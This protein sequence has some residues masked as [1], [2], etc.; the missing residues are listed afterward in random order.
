MIRFLCTQCRKVVDQVELPPLPACPIPPDVWSSLRKIPLG[1]SPLLARPLDYDTLVSI[2]QQLIEG[3][4]PGCD[5][6]PR[7]FY[8]YAPQQLLMLLLSAINAFIEGQDPT[9]HPEE[10]LGALVTLLPK[11]LGSIRITDYRPIGKPC[12]KFVVFSK[13]VDHNFRRALEDYKIV[14][15]EQEGFRAHRSTK[16]QITKLQCL[17]RRARERNTISVRLYLDI[18]NAFN[19]VN[20]RAMLEILRACG[21]PDKDVELFRRMYGNA[22]LMVAN[23]F[24]LSA[25]CTLLRGVLQGAPTSPNVF[26]VAFNPV[27]VLIKACKRGCSP[28]DDFD[29]MGSSGFADDTTLHTDG[30]DAVPA[31]QV[32]VDAISPFC[33]WL[34]LLLNLLKSYVSAVNHATGLQVPTDSIQYHG[35]PFPALSPDS[36][37]KVLGVYMT[38]T[39]NYTQHKEYI[40]TKMRTRCQAL[41]KDDVIPRGELRELAITSGVVS[42]FR[43][44]AGVVPW[45]KTELDAIYKLWIQA[46]KQAWEYPTSLDASPIIVG[47][48]DGGRGCPSAHKVWIDDTMAVLDQ[49]LQLPG[50]ISTLVMEHIRVACSSRGCATLNQ[51][52]KVLRV[53]GTADSIIELLTLRLDE[54]G[55]DISTPWPQRSS[56]LILEALWP[57][58]WQAWQ[59]K[60]KWKGCTELSEEV[61]EQW[62]CAKLYLKICSKLGKVDMLSL[63]QLRPTTGHG[64]TWEELQRQR[65]NITRHEFSQL[66]S[67]LPPVAEEQRMLG[68]PAEAVRSRKDHR[69]LAIYSQ[70]SLGSA[71]DMFTTLPPYIVGKVLSGESSDLIELEFCPGEPIPEVTIDQLSDSMLIAHLCKNRATLNYTADGVSYVTVE[72]LT[73]LSRVWNRAGN[74]AAAVVQPLDPSTLPVSTRLGVLGV[75]LIRD[76]LKEKAAESLLE[77]CSRPTWRI[78]RT[79]L[80]K[81]FPRTCWYGAETVRQEQLKWQFL[82]SG[83]NGLQQMTGLGQGIQRKRVLAPIKQ[84]IPHYIW[85][86]D[87]PIPSNVTIDLSNHIPKRLLAPSGWEVRQ[88]NARVLITDPQ[89]QTF[90]LDAAQYGMLLGLDNMRC[91]A[92][93]TTEPATPTDQF[94]CDLRQECQSQRRC[95]ANFGVPWNRHLITCLQQITEAR[96]LVGPSA[97]TYNPHFPLLVSP[98]SRCATLGAVQEWPDVSALLLL[99]SIAPEDRQTWLQLAAQH[100]QPVWILRLHHPTRA[101]LEDLRALANLQARCV[102]IIPAKSNILHKSG[103][104][105]TAEWDESPSA[106]PA[107]IWL[108]DGR[109]LPPNDSTHASIVFSASLGDWTGRRYDFHWCTG[110]ASTALNLYRRHQQDALQYTFQGLVGG[111]DGSA[112]LRTEQMGAGFAIGRERQPLLTFSAPVGGPY[113]PLRAEAVSLL[114]ALRT[115]RIQLPEQ[116]T[117]LLFVDCLVLLNILMKWGRSEF[118]PHP[119]DIAQFDVL[120]P[121]LTELRTWPGVVVLMKIKSH[122]GCL[123]N[124][125]ADELADQGL[126]SPVEKLFPGPSKYGTLWLRI[127]DSWR[128]RVKSEQLHHIIPRDS[129]PNRSILNKVTEINCLRAVRKRNT[130]FVRHLFHRPEGLV[131]SRNV[132]RC[133]DAVLRVWTKAMAGIYPVQVYLHRIGKATTPYCPHCANDTVE[134]LTH[135]ACICPKF[136]EART[137]AHN[138]LRSNIAA[139]LKDSLLDDWVLLEETPL[140]ATGLQLQPVSAATIVSAS[141]DAV[142]LPTDQDLLDLGR[143][144]P[145]FVLISQERK[146]IAL[147]ELTRPSDIL[148]TQLDEAYRTKKEKYTPVLSA[149]QHYISTGWRIEILPWVVGIR[150]FA[151]VKHLQAALH[152]LNIPRRKWSAIIEDSVLTSVR[153]LTYLHRIRY[154]AANSLS[155]ADRT[156]FPVIPTATSKKRQ[157]STANSMEATRQRWDRLTRNIRQATRSRP[158]SGS[159]PDGK[160]QL[161]RWL[162]QQLGQR[163]KRLRR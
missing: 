66:L 99:D 7:E 141:R 98:Y 55:T 18:K 93:D 87:L 97:V 67:I 56:R 107:Q 134:T 52:Q 142:T 81:W 158:R 53:D 137:A 79:E 102:A 130:Q 129:A 10:W 96:L 113:S 124:E 12:S 72:C 40:M 161:G 45:T 127:R 140:I 148:T 6:F 155:T 117:L 116:T 4:C 61:Q 119:R 25:A 1:T 78:S 21:F 88:R 33:D 59:T 90:G 37:H 44:T 108:V 48:N 123:L 16:R 139:N 8:K 80:S 133:D 14:A 3:K 11:L 86:T 101:A 47:R 118:Q 149:L 23:K 163:L 73:P 144:Q 46:F 32:L 58:V 147:L 100:S 75:A 146:R 106:H 20:H 15:E 145:D 121:L 22:F 151:K 111:T 91:G 112:N 136:R 154:S 110:T 28:Y 162:G 19:A 5:G 29:P 160:Q 41:A 82:P 120:L 2:V 24:G 36:A 71:G 64:P 13:A 26:N 30:P 77:A 132:A 70:P 54:Q 9:V 76:L 17:L 126:K 150:G 62:E 65:C 42:V 135:F 128:H 131:L 84:P 68:T 125:R 43:A 122:A 57:Q 105:Q 159:T 31:M 89:Q 50:E 60:Q 138:Q 157:R 49:C 143:W 27:H 35:A 95:D 83:P 103:F 115:I 51:L 74:Q 156:H 39:E 85:Q 109:I 63:A 69:G 92:S 94:L 34:G 114:Q 38:L 153:A 152:F 104:W